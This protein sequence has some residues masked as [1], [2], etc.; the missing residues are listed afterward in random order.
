M[1]ELFNIGIDEQNV[2]FMIESN[3]NIKDMT[4]EEIIDRMELLKQLGCDE[5]KIK[6]ILIGNPWYLDRC[7]TDVVASI[8]KLSEIG[9]TRL[10]LMVNDNP[11]LLNVDVF[12]I[13]DF[14]ERKLE[15]GYDMD[16]ILDMIDENSNVIVE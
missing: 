9:L 4:D 14:I 7:I 2:K 8:N 15:E 12:E 3:P 11:M 6:N 1:F 13:E 16:D 5:L 10:D